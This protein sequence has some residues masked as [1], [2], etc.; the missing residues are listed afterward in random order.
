MHY[1][2]FPYIIY[3]IIHFIITI[4]SYSINMYQNYYTRMEAF[5]CFHSSSH[6]ELRFHHRSHHQFLFSMP[7]HNLITRL[8]FESTYPFILILHY[9]YSYS[10]FNQSSH[11]HMLVF[12][13]I[14]FNWKSNY[15]FWKLFSSLGLNFY[16]QMRSKIFFGIQ[17]II[18]N[19]FIGI[20]D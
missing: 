13:F 11:I 16:Y 3:S 1:K 7:F 20:V 5:S 8:Y 6:I 14:L 10:Q 19:I 15:N 9:S 17:N 4:W 18:F 2:I 12:Y